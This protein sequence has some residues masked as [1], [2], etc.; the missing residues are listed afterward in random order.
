MIL[1]LQYDVL[2][3]A[4]NKSNIIVHIPG[5]ICYRNTERYTENGGICLYVKNVLAKYVSSVQFN[6]DDAIWVCFTFQPNTMFGASYIPP[7]D[8]SYFKPQ[9]FARLD[10][11]LKTQGKNYLLFSDFNA[12]INCLKILQ[13]MSYISDTLINSHKTDYSHVMILKSICTDNKL[14]VVNNLS[15]SKVNFDN[16]PTFRAKNKWIFQLDLC[17]VSIE[18]CKYIE[19]FGVNRELLPSDHVIIDIK[20]RCNIDIG[21]IITRASQL[22]HYDVPSRSDTK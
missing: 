20:F 13:T 12:T 10:S 9:I 2:W 17:L 21:N 16:G 11:V 4:E 14:L 6:G 22:G 1:S 8:S 15:T 19:M 5:F 3:V 18:L 7:E